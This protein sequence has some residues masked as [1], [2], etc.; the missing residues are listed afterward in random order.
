MSEAGAGNIDQVAEEYRTRV[1]IEKGHVDDDNNDANVEQGAEHLA[2]E[3]EET[4]DQRDDYL[5]QE[6]KAVAEAEGSEDEAED[7]D[8]GDDDEVD[9]YEDWT[10]EQLKD[11]V[12]ARND[13]RGED[14]AKVEV[15]APGNKPELIDALEADDEKDD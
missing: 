8:P 2:R 10:V 15:E 1:G 7:P 3:P 5:S 9:A 12:K 4:S 6:D 14:E 11:E 13:G